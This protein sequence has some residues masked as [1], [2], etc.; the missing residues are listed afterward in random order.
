LIAAPTSGR[1]V[2][3]ELVDAFLCRRHAREAPEDKGK[4]IDAH[5]RGLAT[6]RRL[7]IRLT[8]SSQGRYCEPGCKECLVGKTQT[9]AL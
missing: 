3:K 5:A 1:R 2:T 9:T 4:P 6:S 8:K 7:A